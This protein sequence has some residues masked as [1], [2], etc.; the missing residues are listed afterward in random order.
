MSSTNKTPN[1]E[2]PSFVG[3]DKV[4]WLGDINSAFIKIDTALKE[5]AD[6]LDEHKTIIDEQAE[7]DTN[8]QGLIET[9][10]AQVIAN[11]TSVS[12]MQTAV[13]AVQ[14]VGN[15]NAQT[16]GTGTLNTES[17]NLIG[18]VN[19]VY[20][21]AVSI[22]SSLVNIEKNFEVIDGIKYKKIPLNMRN[23]YEIS[24]SNTYFIPGTVGGGITFDFPFGAEYLQAEILENP[25]NTYM[26]MGFCTK[27]ATLPTI[28][29]QGTG[30]GEYIIASAIG[31]H[32]IASTGIILGAF[33]GGDA[34]Q[35]IYNIC[36]LVR[37]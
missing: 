30:R 37:V 23:Y 20:G 31:K 13:G 33:V 27:D 6:I 35:L 21:K 2:L 16:I 28:M 36:A 18:A 9:L 12:N 3:T 7:V 14:T 25:K 5:I 34:D 19:E 22:N 4:T 15:A 8:Y 1:Y 32:R 17:Q 24:A 11:T 29:T 26:Q 10:Q